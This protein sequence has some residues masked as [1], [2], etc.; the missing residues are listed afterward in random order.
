MDTACELDLYY[1]LKFS[2]D[3]GARKEETAKAL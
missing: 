3:I 2:Y 1:N